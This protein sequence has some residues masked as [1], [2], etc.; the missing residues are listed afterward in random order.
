MA[1]RTGKTGPLDSDKAAESR[2]AKATGYVVADGTQVN[3]GGRL[4]VAGETVQATANEAA[5]WLARGYVTR[6]EA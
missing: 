4:Y 3:H 2:K 5:E 6:K 1:T